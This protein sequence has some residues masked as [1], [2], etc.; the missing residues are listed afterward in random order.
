LY[1]I[2]DH[3]QF[4]QA[5]PTLFVGTSTQLRAFGG[6]E[7]KAGE[8]VHL[9][10]AAPFLHI[11]CATGLTTT[12]QVEAGEIHGS[13]GAASVV[14]SG[15][16]PEFI[17]QIN[18]TARVD[19]TSVSGVALTASSTPYRQATVTARKKVT[20]I[21]KASTDN[22]GTVWIGRSATDISGATPL[23]PGQSMNLFDN[24]DLA[25]YFL[26]VNTANDGVSIAYSS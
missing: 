26:I 24:G 22:V 25:D 19:G 6:S 11:V 5:A 23:E 2:S 17:E 10:P 12:A 21:D 7:L 18:A 15:G 13:A 4:T 9:N 1:Y 14:G 20:D 8:V 16:S 3:Q